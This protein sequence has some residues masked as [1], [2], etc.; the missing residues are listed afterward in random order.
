MWAFWSYVACAAWLII[1]A[2]T[3]AHWGAAFNLWNNLIVG[4]VIGVTTLMFLMR[5][6]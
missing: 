2:F 6:S 3:I 5:K 1:S 4:I